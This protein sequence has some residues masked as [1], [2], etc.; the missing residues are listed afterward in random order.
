VANRPFNQDSEDAGIPT[1]HFGDPQWSEKLADPTEAYQRPKHD[2]P[3]P[4]QASNPFQEMEGSESNTD[5]GRTTLPGG[6]AASARPNQEK[7][8]PPVQGPK[9]PS[10]KLAAGVQRGAL[11][12][13]PVMLGQYEIVKE[14]GRG[15]MGIVYEGFQP[16][17]DRRVALKVLPEHLAANDALVARFLVE[18][19]AVAKFNHP[20]I[21]AIYEIGEDDGM[22]FFAMEYV[23]GRTLADL[24]TKRDMEDF[25][26]IARL[27]RD[28]ARALDY[29]HRSGVIHRDIKPGNI[30]VTT[31]GVVKIM[32]FGL[33]RMEGDERLTMTGMTL[34]TPAYMSP[35]QAGSKLSGPVDHRSDLYSLG[36]VLY[37]LITRQLPIDGRNKME[38]LRNIVDKKVVPP[39]KHTPECPKPLERIVMKSLAKRTED[40]YQRGA[41]FGD[42]LDKFLNDSKVMSVGHATGQRAVGSVAR[43]GLKL[44]IAATLVFAGVVLGVAYWIAKNPPG[45]ENPPT[46]ALTPR[47]TPAATI[48]PTADP[49]S[50]Q[51]TPTPGATPPVVAEALPPVPASVPLLLSQGREWEA[52]SLAAILGK[53]T[54]KLSSQDRG[55]LRRVVSDSHAQWQARYNDALSSH[56]YVEATSLTLQLYALSGLTGG[57]TPPPM[58]SWEGLDPKISEMPPAQA[59]ETILASV[60]EQ[61]ARRWDPFLSWARLYNVPDYPLR[62]H[63][64]VAALS[65]HTAKEQPFVSLSALFALADEAPDAVAGARWTSRIVDALKADPRGG[66]LL[67]EALSRWHPAIDFPPAS[68][69]ASRFGHAWRMIVTLPLGTPEKPWPAEAI[70]EALEALPSSTLNPFN[71]DALPGLAAVQGWNATPVAAPRGRYFQDATTLAMVAQTLPLGADQGSTSRLLKLMTESNER[72]GDPNPPFPKRWRTK[73]E[74]G[75][76]PSREVEMFVESTVD[77]TQWRARF[78]SNRDGNLEDEWWYTPHRNVIADL[79]VEYRFGVRQPLAVRLGVERVNEDYGLRVEVVSA[80][81]FSAPLPKLSGQSLHA[82]LHDVDSDGVWDDWDDKGVRMTIAVTPSDAVVSQAIT[83]TR[84]GMTGASAN[85]IPFFD[86]VIG[87]LKTQFIPADTIVMLGTDAFTFREVGPGG[88]LLYFDPAPTVEVTLRLSGGSAE[89]GNLLAQYALGQVEL[90]LAS[91]SG[92]V[93]VKLPAGR[94][95]LSVSSASGS[96]KATELIAINDRLTAPVIISI[97]SSK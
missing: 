47:P 39:T 48:A 74:L 22:H 80:R 73:F 8:R 54:E 68:A 19:R 40:R 27:V 53:D 50:T 35:E 51:P 75:D 43:T 17:L 32:D 52:V 87:A 57:A 33:A 23:P 34:G 14:L 3:A 55:L 7:S 10:R 26:M 72:P 71:G 93:K 61:P 13:S 96:G 20:N 67:A 49:E 70:A 6:T 89:P 41:D 45:S 30:M 85:W 62:H 64:V 91:V 11:G 36:V 83:W 12:Q 21:C 92:D 58:P 84:A 9:L 44:Y 42:D 63:D 31:E 29:A 69:I 56:R 77:A 94:A 82:V 18:A 59:L 88:A 25:E 97:S 76:G 65:E 46:T 38:I 5:V 81:T 60:A 2:A 28:S 86:R 16:K 66:R 90:P 78:D 15:G 24:I 4:D 95:M 37:E 1:S 79:P